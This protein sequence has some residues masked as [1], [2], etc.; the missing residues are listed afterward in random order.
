[1]G[2][3]RLRPYRERRALLL[4]LLDPL[5]P[6][7]QPVPATADLDVALQWYETLPAIGLEG[8]VAKRA[9]GVYRPGRIWQ[10]IRHT[11]TVDA[12]VL[13][14]TGTADRPQ[15]LVVQLPDGRRAV[16]RQLPLPVR[17]EL[18][19]HLRHTPGEAARTGDGTAYRAIAPGLVVEVEAGTTR[20]VTV[21][22]HRVRA[23][24]PAAGG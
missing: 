6:P 4:Q 14:H 17:R 18:A 11:E 8:V 12:V 16:S 5:G 2:D 24:P 3:V 7:L 20:H 19:A 23:V 10:K 13:G 9:N 22:V 15:T 1:M 21:S